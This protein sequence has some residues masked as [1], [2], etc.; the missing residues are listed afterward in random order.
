VTAVTDGDWLPEAVRALATRYGRRHEL[1]S[2][3]EESDMVMLCGSFA[4]NPES[5]TGHPLVSRFRRKC[6]VYCE[7]DSYLPLLPGVYTS[8]LRGVSTWLGRVRSHA[9][10][11]SYGYYANEAVN[12]AGKAP[13]TGLGPKDLLFSFEGSPNS[14]LRL[15]LFKMQLA[16]E[17]ALVRDTS[18]QY[19]HFDHRASGRQWGQQRYVETMER[20]RFVLCP[21]GAGTGTLRLFEAMSLGAAPVLLSDRY[22]L[23]RGP[24]WDEFLVRVRERRAGRVAAILRASASSSTVRGRQARESWEQWFAPDVLFDG[25]V[26]AA[27]DTMRCSRRVEPLFRLT[28]PLLVVRFRLDRTVRGWVWKARLRLSALRPTKR[29]QGDGRAHHRTR[30]TLI[31]PTERSRRSRPEPTS[32]AMTVAG[33]E[34][35]STE[36]SNATTDPE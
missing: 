5:L 35:G 4:R 25:L 7:D 30:R 19:K 11:A 27:A 15:R 12:E 33:P 3:P 20:S 21:R 29:E 8:P 18:K 14:R 32:S 10:V 16:P 31:L 17:E 1:A 13:P 24:K 34:P 23:P 36:S 9:Y 22:V 2:S 26:D 6:V 28:G